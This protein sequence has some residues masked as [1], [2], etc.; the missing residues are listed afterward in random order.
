[1]RTYFNSGTTLVLLLSIAVIATPAV[2]VWS[3]SQS[4][5]LTF[6]EASGAVGSIGTAVVIAFGAIFAVYQFRLFR[7]NEPHL[8]VTQSVTHRVVSDSYVAIVIT[9]ELR[10]SSRV[11]VS[12]RE[13]LFRLQQI[14]GL[15]DDEVEELYVGSFIDQE[16]VDI[17]WPTIEEIRRS[18]NQDMLSI[19]PGQV[20]SETYAFIVDRQFTTF[21]INSI[22]HNPSA[23][24]IR[25]GPKVWLATTVYTVDIDEWRRDEN[26]RQNL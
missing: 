15:S 13:T 16:Y 21:L 7:H 25:S 9:A 5:G 23:S 17:R 11:S 24:T 19:E 20:H 14:D 26:P 22:F 8:N 1:M 18:Q 10:N 12:I 6:A 4:F 2:A 3:L